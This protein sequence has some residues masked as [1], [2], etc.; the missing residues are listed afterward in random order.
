[1][2]WPVTLCPRASGR[3]GLRARASEGQGGRRRA[4]CSVSRQLLSDNGDR[5]GIQGLVRQGQEPRAGLRALL[6]GAGDAEQ[7][8]VAELASA[9]F[10]TARRNAEVL[11]RLRGRSPKNV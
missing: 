7:R 9:G 11:A 8:R 4:S 5:G 3:S 1:M 2:R 10:P 6:P